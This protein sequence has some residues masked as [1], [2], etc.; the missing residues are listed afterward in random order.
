M[1]AR[2]GEGCVPSGVPPAGVISNARRASMFARGGEGC[3]PS[4][5]VK[6]PAP[7]AILSN[8]SVGLSDRQLVLVLS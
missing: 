1:S 8:A 2:G 7:C 6:A 5:V 3:V 4:G